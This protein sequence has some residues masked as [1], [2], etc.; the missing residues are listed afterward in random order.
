[1]ITDLSDEANDWM[2]NKLVFRSKLVSVHNRYSISDFTVKHIGDV[3]PD[4]EH[5]TDCIDNDRMF[6]ARNEFASI[7]SR[8]YGGAQESE[9]A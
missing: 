6:S 3:Y 9:G 7:T 1:M 2:R 4:D 8:F 5:A